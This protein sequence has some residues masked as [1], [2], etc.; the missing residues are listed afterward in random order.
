MLNW[1]GNFTKA[2]QWCLS[3]PTH[4]QSKFVN[5]IYLW[6]ILILSSH[7]CLDLS[8]DLFPSGFPTKTL[9]TSITCTMCTTCPCPLHPPWFYH[10]NNTVKPVFKGTRMKYKPISSVKFLWSQE[11]SPPPPSPKVKTAG[12]K[13]K[14]YNI[15]MES[16]NK[17]TKNSW[18][19]VHI[20]FHII[21]I[22][23][24]LSAKPQL[25]YDY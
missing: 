9:S 18:F 4:I 25:T 24:A 7:L 16:K 2:N 5:P 3:W 22:H 15:K 14:Q 8:S 20:C 13:W 21:L 23:T 19:D 12:N 11:C 10:P 1:S 17:I 6:Y